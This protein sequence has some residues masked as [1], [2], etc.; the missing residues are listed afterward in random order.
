MVSEIELIIL[1]KEGNIQA[2]D[3]FYKQNWRALY[4][5]AYR[6]T[7]S[8]EDA[9]DL[10]QTVFINLW[11][12]R[13]N[14]EPERYNASYLFRMLKNNIINFYKQDSARKKRLEK[15]L[16]FDNADQ[17]T[18][19]DS[20]I[21]KELSVVIEGEIKELPRKMQEV[22]ILSRHQNLSVNEISETLN[23]TPR[24]VKNQLSNALKILRTKLGMF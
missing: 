5:M 10:V 7:C 4:Q 3:Q 12:C 15:L 14:L 18:N 1:I 22:F 6:S 8:Q 19:E 23:I 24:T 13:Y 17:Y 9:K 21:A 2:F 20:L 16:Q 11:N